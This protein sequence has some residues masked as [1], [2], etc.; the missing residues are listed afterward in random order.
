MRTDDA[1]TLSPTSQED[2]R[3]RVIRSVFVNGLSQSEAARTHRVSRTS[4]HNWCKAHEAGGERRL[5]S[6]KRGRPRESPL[7]GHQAATVVNLVRDNCPDQL[8]LGFA[9]WS[10]AAVQ[11]LLAE[12][13]GVHRS[14][15][16]IGRY[17]QRWN[18]TPQKPVQKAYEKDPQAVQQW[19][20]EDYPAIRR[21]AGR[22]GAEI[23]WGDQMAMRSDHQTGTSY[24]PKGQTPV[25]PGTGQRFRCNL[26]STVTN[27]GTVRFMIFTRRFTAALMIE[28]LQRLIRDVDGKVFLILDQHPVHRSKQVT[29]WLDAHADQLEVYFLPGYSPELNPDEYLN[30]DVKAN[31]VGRQRP[32]DQAQMISQVRTYLQSTQKQPEIVRGYF[33]HPDVTYAAR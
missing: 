23:H 11:K 9:L 1:R 31:A 16:T 21:K 28:F 26:I 33:D 25:V 24:S 27:R 29:R 14:V 2:L 5:R 8:K 10:R 7:K 32:S 13:F 19:L 4:V 15:W 17:L 18:F 3:K 30:Q 20:D 22:E 6:N 12:R